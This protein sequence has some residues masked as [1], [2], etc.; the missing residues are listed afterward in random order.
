MGKTNFSIMDDRFD[1]RRYHN[2]DTFRVTSTAGAVQIKNEKG[3]LSLQKVKVERYISGKRPG[4]AKKDYNLEESD[5]ESDNNDFVLN[6][7][8][9]ETK[10]KENYHE[11]DEL[12]ESSSDD[13][14]HLHDTDNVAL[15]TVTEESTT[16]NI[17]ELDDP[18]L[19]RLFA[20]KLENPD[21]ENAEKYKIEQVETSEE[22]NENE[23][24]S[25]QHRVVEASDSNTSSEDD[26]DDDEEETVLRRRHLMRQRALARA[27]V[28]YGEG[29]LLAKENE[30]TDNE[31]SSSEE[32][33]D[34]ESSETEEEIRRKP[35]FVRKRDRITTQ[36]REREERMNWML[37]E[38]EKRKSEI[39]RRESLRIVESC[40]KEMQ[41][42]DKQTKIDPLIEQLQQVCTDDENE[43]DEYDGWKLRELK[44]MKKDRE[45]R[46]LIRKEVAD[47]ERRRNM[48]DEELK[49]DLRLL[50]RVTTNKSIKGRYKFMQKYYHKGSYFMEQEEK[51]YSRDFSSATLEDH[52]DKSVLPKVM[53]VKNFGRSGRTKYTH[54]LHQDTTELESPWSMDTSQNLKFQLNHAAAMKST[55]ERP[56]ARSQN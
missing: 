22:A 23:M 8:E 12:P 5:N 49:W 28:G 34:D 17:N 1:N 29:E 38:D 11:I 44:R 40:V 56:S 16:Q 3:E 35:V 43:E 47:I 2:Q 39:R 25:R 18:R 27:R 19:K 51:L 15:K 50:P 33:T 32:T 4:Y 9:A 31:S 52:F 54:L 10:H 21:L 30:I 20:V 14:T 13:D 55:F 42:D 53:Q 48:T 7:D 36:E 6:R 46:E 26:V 24:K 37:Q 45:E 41:E